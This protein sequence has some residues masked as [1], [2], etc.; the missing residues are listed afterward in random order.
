MNT[1]SQRG[2]TLVELLVVIAIIGVLIALLLPAIQAAREAARRSQCQTNLKNI[3][4][5]VQMYHDTQQRLPSSRRTY[6][7]I[8]WA[9]ELWP[10]LEAGNIST[11]WNP[12][13]TYYGQ[14][15]EARQAFVPIY[16]CPTRRA[17][18][19]EALSVIGDNNAQD[20]SNG[21]HY[22]GALADYACNTGDNSPDASANDNSYE[23]GDG[24]FTEPTGPFRHAGR[25]I[26]GD[27]DVGP[28]TPGVDDLSALKIAYS[29]RLAQIEDGTSNT[30]FIGEKHVPQDDRWF[31][32]IDA[33]DNS[34]Y[35]ADSWATCGRKGGHLT[36]IS[37]PIDGVV[38]PTETN[39]SFGSWHIG[40]CHFVFG[41]GSVHAVNNDIDVYML[42]QICHKSDGYTVDLDGKGV[43]FPVTQY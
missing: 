7:Y 43:P 13:Q 17:P 28:I 6:D 31:G 15:D 33:R 18:G 42:G 4:L 38:E 36:P 12:T 27:D 35:N 20:A 30:V 1:R 41:D 23:R 9:A 14:T 16:Y 29:V 37:K 26:D 3:G 40:I 5:A 22:P 21:D 24:T 10:Y 8:T 39:K 11:I 34:I 2:F 19:P 32:H 25:G